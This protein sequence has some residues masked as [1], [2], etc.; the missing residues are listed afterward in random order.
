M[1]VRVSSLSEDRCKELYAGKWDGERLLEHGLVTRPTSKKRDA[2]GR[3]IGPPL[4][5]DSQRNVLAECKT[6]GRWWVAQA[7]VATSPLEAVKGEGKR[8]HGGLGKTVLRRKEI[9]A[10]YRCVLIRAR[11]GDER[12]IAALLAL[13]LGMRATEIVTRQV[14]DLDDEDWVLGVDKDHAKTGASERGMEVPKILRPMLARL[15]KAKGPDQYIFGDGNKPHWRDWVRKS[16]RAL[17]IGAKVPLETAHGMRGA[18][19]DLAREAG[20]T[21]ELVARQIGHEDES[22]GERSYTTKRT[23]AGSK[24]R[25]TLRVLEGGLARKRGE[26]A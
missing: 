14:R 25:R 3:S 13:L 9:R 2:E 17:C 4:A 8:N 15:I 7:W 18:H 1:K 26:S 6:F 22:T 23:A 10:F 24:Q 12:A 21:G 20:A 5:V 11:A 19:T 16:I